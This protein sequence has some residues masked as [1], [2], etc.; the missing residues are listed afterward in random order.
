[1]FNKLKTDIKGQKLLGV[2]KIKALRLCG[3]KDI[4]TASVCRA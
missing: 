1:M 2:K 4:H 3:N